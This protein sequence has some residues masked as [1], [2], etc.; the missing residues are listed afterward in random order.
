LIDL[1]GLGRRAMVKLLRRL[2]GGYARSVGQIYDRMRD[3]RSNR[4]GERRP[5]EKISLCFL[6]EVGR[7]FVVFCFSLSMR[8]LVLESPLLKRQQKLMNDPKNH[9]GRRVRR[10]H[11][12]ASPPFL[13]QRMRRGRSRGLA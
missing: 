2:D 4:Q 1:R 10:S 6:E 7:M 5:A 3:T 9:Q 11:F 13:H 8:I 12:S